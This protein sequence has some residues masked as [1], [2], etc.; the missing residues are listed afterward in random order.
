MG[1]VHSTLEGF[2]G[3]A[4]TWKLHS[5]L[6][7][8][9]NISSKKILKTFHGV[10]ILQIANFSLQALLYPKYMNMTLNTRVLFMV[11]RH[12]CYEKLGSIRPPKGTPDSHLPFHTP[13]GAY[14]YFLLFCSYLNCYWPLA[15]NLPP[16]STSPP[17]SMYSGKDVSLLHICCEALCIDWFLWIQIL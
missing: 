16:R 1:A 13:L 8:P 11:I 14:V 9:L 6:K 10:C 12:S 4:P 15:N 2:K 3:K 17:P 5:I 7:N